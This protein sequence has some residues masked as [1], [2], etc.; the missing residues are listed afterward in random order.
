MW[1]LWEKESKQIFRET[2]IPEPPSDL[3]LERDWAILRHHWCD[4]LGIRKQTRL[5]TFL[6][7]QRIVMQSSN[8]TAG[9]NKLSHILTNPRGNW[10]LRPFDANN[11]SSQPSSPT[12]PFHITNN[13]SMRSRFFKVSLTSSYSHRL[14][15]ARIGGGNI[16]SFFCFLKWPH[17]NCGRPGRSQINGSR[18]HTTETMEAMETMETMER[19][20]KIGWEQYCK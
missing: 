15:L 16:F 17:C 5:F 10:K 11:L 19:A 4:G 2:E 9:K 14:L 18:M 12:N 7:K 3:F 8:L 13:I 1:Q 20:N 6:T